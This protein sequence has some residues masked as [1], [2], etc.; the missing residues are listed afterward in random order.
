[1]LFPAGMGSTCGEGIPSVASGASAADAHQLHTEVL[2][3][4]PMRR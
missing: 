1:M 4:L 3:K 2:H